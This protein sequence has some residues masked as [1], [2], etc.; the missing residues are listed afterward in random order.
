M[1]YLEL[2]IDGENIKVDGNTLF[3]KLNQND[4]TPQINEIP[5]SSAKLGQT[6]NEKYIL[7]AHF[8]DR[9]SA[10]VSKDCLKYMKFGK[11][12]NF[13]ESD[14]YEWLNTEYLK[15]LEEEFGENSV[16][17]HE[18][19]LLS[20][21]GLEDYG[22]IENEVSL[23][24]IDQYRMYRKYLKPL[25]DNWW[26]STPNSTDSGTSRALVECIS[27]DGHISYCNCKCLYCDD[28]GVRP[29]FI[30]DSSTLVNVN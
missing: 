8:S 11:N 29:Y 4:E 22:K 15:E 13:A 3:I 25:N 18:T 9:T 26:L 20:L 24:T 10:L 27:S 6:V 19:N 23:L 21:D 14:V 30:I 7:V 2:K 12:N 16:K 1:G 17:I 5:L 28:L